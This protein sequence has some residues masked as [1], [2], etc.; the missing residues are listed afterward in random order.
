MRVAALVGSPRRHMNTD[1]LVRAAMRGAASQGAEVEI[2]YLDRLEI[3]PCKACPKHPHPNHCFFF[4]DM[5]R[6]YEILEN[7]DGII[8]G[9][10]VYYGS[11][12]AQVK[13]V[14]D[15]ANCLTWIS[16]DSEGRPVFMPRLQKVKKGVV[17]LVSDTTRNP[18]AVLT[19]IRLFFHDARIETA[20]ELFIPDADAGRGARSSE[21]WLQEAHALGVR[22]AE[23]IEEAASSSPERW[24]GRHGEDSSSEM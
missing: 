11:V 2:L 21:E 3:A 12:P 20:G 22:L 15:R 9:S 24:S 16:R 6:V 1:T 23:A 7:A 14:I 10:P 13:L 19:P 18:S 5:Q 4:D 17:I 8:L